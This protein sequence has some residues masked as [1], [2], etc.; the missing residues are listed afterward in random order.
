MSS[1]IYIL[2]YF[3]NFFQVPYKEP[4]LHRA[5]QKEKQYPPYYNRVG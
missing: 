4:I 1:Y 3:A 2:L 5:G